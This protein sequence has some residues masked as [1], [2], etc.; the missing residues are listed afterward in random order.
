[1]TKTVDDYINDPR[2]IDDPEM[3][4]APECV[5]E[6]HAVRLML[7]D[8]TAGMTT[9]EHVDYINARGKATLA[10]WGLSHL[11]VDSINREP[12]QPNN[13][14]LQQGMAVR[15]FS[16]NRNNFSPAGGY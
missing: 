11:Y 1:M 4:E 6:I 14:I 7:Q 13:Q 9:K 3:M 5:R 16:E 15:G 2:I 8:E 10:K 12:E